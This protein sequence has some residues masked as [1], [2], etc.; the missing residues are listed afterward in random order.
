VKRGVFVV[1]R[2]G[3]DNTLANWQLLALRFAES[4]V[5][6]GI[7]IAAIIAIVV[8]V[9]VSFGL[10]LDRLPELA[11]TL[12]LERLPDLMV[13]LG[14]IAGYFLLVALVVAI[15]LTAIHAFVVAG[16]MRVYVDGDRTAGPVDTAPR[17]GYAV[18]TLQRWWSGAADGWWP[19]FWIYNLA[20]GAASVILLIPLLPT[21]ALMLVLRDDDSAAL[22]AGIGCFGIVITALL[23]I[24]VGVA[25]SLWT[26]RA[27]AT[28]TARRGTA[29]EALSLASAAIRTDLGRHLLIALAVIVVGMA[30]SSFFAG[31]SFVGTF[32]SLAARDQPLLGLFALPVRALGW[33][34]STIF[35]AAIGGWFLSSYASLANE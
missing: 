15:V 19:V 30:G 9:L 21:F 14:A 22:V 31:F 13:R 24:V 32:T 1:L 18:F 6:A 35:S 25:V 3:F 7:I 28:W 27:I 23:A 16:C 5:F 17:R 4:V 11:S 26:T 2:R 33:I 8:P 10:N 20:W 29:R 12:E 34:L